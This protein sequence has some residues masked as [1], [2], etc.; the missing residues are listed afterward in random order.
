M[1]LR[2]LALVFPLL[3]APAFAATVHLKLQAENP[4]AGGPVKVTVKALSRVPV[5]LPAEPI[6]YV[7]EGK[8]FKPRPELRCHLSNGDAAVRLQ[9]DREVTASCELPLPAAGRQRIRVG[10]R[11]GET[12]STSNAVT[13]EAKGSAQAAA[14][15]E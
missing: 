11:L 2:S 8:G 4:A 14:A 9:A 6:V 7:D 13:V 15:T 12:V 10:Y 1:R 5:S 3:A